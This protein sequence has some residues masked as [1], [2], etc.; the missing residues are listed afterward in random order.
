MCYF[1]SSVSI[2]LF[3]LDCDVLFVFL[4]F[5]L[6]YFIISILAS[7][8]KAVAEEYKSSLADLNFN[9]KP[10]INML[11][12]LAE[13]NINNASVIVQTIVNHIQK[14][15]IE[16]KLPGFYLV[17]SIIKNIGKEYVPLFCQHIVTLFTSVFEK[18]DETTR[19]L[20]F[21]LRQTW[22]GPLPN[23]VLYN[24]DL[25]IRKMDP[26]WPVT[27]KPSTK[28]IHINPKFL[29]G[30][31]DEKKEK[32]EKA[33]MISEAVSAFRANI[34]QQGEVMK[35]LW[36]TREQVLHKRVDLKIKQMKRLEV[37]ARKKLGAMEKEANNQNLKPNSLRDPR[38]VKVST[39]ASSSMAIKA[40]STSL[41]SKKSETK[42]ADGFVS[43]V[44]KKTIPSPEKP[45]KTVKS[46]KSDAVHSNLSVK[47]SPKKDLKDL[48]STDVSTV[49][50]TLKRSSETCDTINSDSVPSESQAKK[51]KLVEKQNIS[52]N[53]MKGPPVLFGN[54][55]QDQ[56]RSK[57]Q[58]L[59]SNIQGWAQYKAVH[60]DEF[61]SPTPSVE[62]SEG[63]FRFRRPSVN[64]D[65][66][67]PFDHSRFPRFRFQRGGRF[68]GRY[69]GRRPQYVRGPRGRIFSPSIGP[70]VLDPHVVI[71]QAEE[72]YHSGRIS[73]GEYLDLCHDLQ[74]MLESK[75]YQRYKERMSR[76]Q[77]IGQSRLDDS[78]NEFRSNDSSV[79][80]RVPNFQ[81][82]SMKSQGTIPAD[83]TSSPCTKSFTLDG[84]VRTVQ[85]RGHRAFVI[86]DNNELKE[87]SFKSEPRKVL[88]EGIPEPITM[89]F[90][91]KEV[92]FVLNG[93]KHCMKFG[94]P[95][96]EIYIDN[97]PYEAQFGGPPFSILLDGRFLNICLSGPPPQ[98]IVSNEIDYSS[99]ESRENYESVPKVAQLFE[100]GSNA[101]NTDISAQDVDMRVTP[102][103]I[104]QPSILNEVATVVKDVD[105]RV[106]PGV[107]AEMRNQS[108][109][110]RFEM[111]EKN[112]ID[113]QNPGEKFQSISDERKI[114]EKKW[115]NSPVPVGEWKPTIADEKSS[116]QLKNN[117]LNANYDTYGAI[118]WREQERY[119]EPTSFAANQES[120]VYKGASEYHQPFERKQAAAPRENW[121]GMA[122][123]WRPPPFYGRH[124]RAARMRAPRFGPQIE[125][126][127]RPRLHGWRFE[128]QSQEPQQ[129]VS[130]TQDSFKN[131]PMQPTIPRISEPSSNVTEFG[132]KDRIAETSQDSTK[133]DVEALFAKL[134]AAG[135]INTSTV[136]EPVE[137]PLDV[138]KTP[139]TENNN[140]KEEIIQSESIPEVE[141]KSESLK[142]PYPNVISALHQGSQCCSCGMRFKDIQSQQYSQHL[143]WHFRINRREKE[144]FKKPVSKRWYYEIEDWIQFEE[145]DDCEERAPSFF[146]L[147]AET[148][149]V[150]VPTPIIPSIAATGDIS[151]E[152]SVC[153][154]QFQ[155]FWV[156]EEEEWHLKNAI[157]HDNE[158]YHPACY[159]DF[160]KGSHSGTLGILR[161]FRNASGEPGKLE[162]LAA[163]TFIDVPKRVGGSQFFSAMPGV[164]TWGRAQKTQK[165][166]AIIQEENDSAVVLE[167]VNEAMKCMLYEM[168]MQEEVLLF[169][170]S[171]LEEVEKLCSLEALS[172]AEDILEGRPGVEEIIGLITE[173]E[174]ES[175][176]NLNAADAKMV[177]MQ[178]G[179]ITLKVKAESLQSNPNANSSETDIGSGLENKADEF[180]P[181]TPDPR[182]QVL[183]PVSKGSELSGLCCIM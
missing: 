87:L 158:A 175:E 55:D 35:Q 143:D 113:M 67:P 58:I 131:M 179:G 173:S 52:D 117:N 96:R 53:N 159:E 130:L 32:V 21:K 178:S 136:S 95:T 94:T 161:E 79:F 4:I 65:S 57:L 127:V 71:A 109:N 120:S 5:F 64:M 162:T 60:P 140:E 13:E 135:I 133:I 108:F 105:W 66:F 48:I 103:D 83:T 80:P 74:K 68:N 102:G 151:E 50:K 47:S 14:S 116:L 157:R 92:E 18:V 90:D 176:S 81:K 163:Q 27:A 126:N 46:T 99:S 8:A 167:E 177:V 88:I 30:S 63:R 107:Q 180:R 138:D 9:S 29:A 42:S 101:S 75:E 49:T 160:K 106:L 54:E 155:L 72:K 146:D 124:S 16:M 62:N 152:C 40:G 19:S 149:T 110:S 44:T 23:K 3:V 28:G 111:N 26:A 2:S 165:I 150:E 38:M 171:I 15:S 139:E 164:P 121:R 37:S 17:D 24:L 33:P 129:S 89:S 82:D 51:Q 93:N 181:P 78:N 142:V 169:T 100:T 183:P 31:T 36:E 125:R 141:F 56:R 132:Q 145:F 85:F 1:F 86:M 104:N 172:R 70:L 123:S 25:Q 43:N 11:T 156:Q 144:E 168:E 170:T 134:M 128:S 12:M 115:Y 61:G 148:E 137:E 77:N 69:T 182:F 147:Q 34:Q 166:S 122:F 119:Q 45:K 59:D 84:K 7:M 22:N 10:H 97:H 91:G 114:T 73:E 20:L 153:G 118:S 76:I 6:Y 41:D 112:N 174:S 39:D 154:E 98:V